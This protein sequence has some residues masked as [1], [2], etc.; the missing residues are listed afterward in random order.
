[1]K[2]TTTTTTG[3]GDKVEAISSSQV[4]TELGITRLDP[5]LFEIPAGYTEATSSAELMPA[6]ATGG[7]LAEALFGSTVDGSSAAAPKKAGAVRIGILEPINRTPRT[8]QA[9]ALR[10]DL[11]GKFSKAPYQRFRSPAPHQGR[12]IRKRRG[13]M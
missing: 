5:A 1:M 11:V 2:V 13:R 8:L 7:S 12:S 10:N 4:V 9:S 3:E 6:L